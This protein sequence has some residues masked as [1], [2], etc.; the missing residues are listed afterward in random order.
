[1]NTK[2]N[3]SMKLSSPMKNLML[4]IIGMMLAVPVSARKWELDWESGAAVHMGSKD[5][6][7]F[8][9]RTGQ[10]GIVPYHTSQLM[11]LGADISKTIGRDWR[12]EAGT[13]LVGAI[14]EPAYMKSEVYA[15]VDRLYISGSWKMLHL[16][17][18]MKPRERSLED[19]SISGG[20]IMYSRNARNIP[21]IN[22]WSD[23]IYFEKGHWFGIKGNIA[24]YQMIDNRFVRAAMIHNKALSMKFALGGKVD[25][26]FGF[27]H[28][29]QWGGDSPIYGKQPAAFS[30]FMKVFLAQ[31]G[32]EGATGSDRMNVLGNHLGKEYFRLDW[33][34]SEFTLTAQYDKP[35]ED[36]SGMKFKNAPDGIWSLQCALSDRN[37]WVTDVIYEFISTTWQSGPA[38]DR[39]AT[40]E[41][42][43]KQDP[44]DPTY[45]KIIL[46]GCDSYFAN[47]EYKSGWTNYNRVI[48]CPLLLPSHPGPDG[49]TTSMA[50][51][52][53]RGHHFG[54]KGVAFNMIPYKV[55]AT[56]TRNYGNYHQAESSV[57]TRIPQ[58]LSLALE[59]E[60]GSRLWTPLP[61]RCIV[62]LYGDIGDL[63]RDSIGLSL[64]LIYWGSRR[65]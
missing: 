47:G 9:Q 62:G 4:M 55:L 42:M 15:L 32:G 56:Y 25:F 6:L 50:S 16:D 5:Y 20:N 17:L 34:A 3:P 1:M 28:W 23:W 48:G 57:F 40:Q 12:I 52:R 10:D 35:F 18:G 30:D 36:G 60:F 54:L 65:F 8:W 43:S 13:N 49:V 59:L 21:G 29:A 7:P 37:A 24:H 19:I 22:A 58:Q 44:L 41:E 38:H 53:T 45:G 33:R 2:L 51:T 31:K 14:A 26:S 39:P 11:T 27:E 46:G 64:K 63:Y 61:V